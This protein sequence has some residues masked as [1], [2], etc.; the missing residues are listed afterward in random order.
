MTGD[1][2]SS[3]L[4]DRKYLRRLSS[5]VLPCSALKFHFGLFVKGTVHINK[6]ISVTVPQLAKRL[7]YICSPEVSVSDISKNLILLFIKKHFFYYFLCSGIR[8]R[9]EEY[10]L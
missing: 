4:E 3:D 1:H 9:S 10:F 8:I 5:A 6:N 7:F 2:R